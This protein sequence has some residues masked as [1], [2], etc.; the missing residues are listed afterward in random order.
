MSQYTIT[1]RLEGIPVEIVYECDYGNDYTSGDYEL[2]IEAVNFG[3]DEA[4]LVDVLP[5]LSETDISMLE[6]FIQ[7]ASGFFEQ[8]AEEMVCRAEDA[9]DLAMGR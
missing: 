5:A 4:T 8:G 1:A 7:G 2:W 3:Y 6:D 9:Y